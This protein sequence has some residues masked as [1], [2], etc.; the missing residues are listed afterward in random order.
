MDRKSKLCLSFLK[1]NKENAYNKFKGI[2]SEVSNNFYATGLNV[3]ITTL[4]TTN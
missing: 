1:T 2:N 4:I 3:N